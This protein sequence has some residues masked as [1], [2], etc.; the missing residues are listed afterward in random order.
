MDKLDHV[1][2]LLE[3]IGMPPAQQSTLC[4]L[5]LLAMADVKKEGS[6]KEATNNWIRIH[7]IISFIDR[8]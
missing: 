5:A 7:D 2:Y 1:K 4:C 6:F 3:Q 8:E